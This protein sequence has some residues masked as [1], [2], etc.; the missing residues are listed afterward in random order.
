MKDVEK[1]SRDGDD[2]EKTIKRSEMPKVNILYLYFKSLYLLIFFSVLVILLFLYWNYGKFRNHHSARPLTTF[3]AATQNRN[4]KTL[5]KIFESTSERVNVLKRRL[6]NIQS[7]FQE[8]VPEEQKS[9]I[10]EQHF[11]EQSLL[12]TF[13]WLHLQIL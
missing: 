4:H 7:I 3:E 2:Q 5:F 1:S 8:L 12:K 10:L 6:V 11:S 13:Q 9:I